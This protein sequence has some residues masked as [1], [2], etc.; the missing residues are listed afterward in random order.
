[1]FTGNMLW[2]Q[3]WRKREAPTSTA[4]LSCMLRGGRGGGGLQ[5]LLTLFELTTMD[6]WQDVMRQGMDSAG[7][8]NQPVTD[9]SASY[10][11]FFVTFICVS[12]FFLSRA[13][14]GVFIKQVSSLFPR[15]QVSIPSMNKSNLSEQLAFVPVSCSNLRLQS[16]VEQLCH[17]MKY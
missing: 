10:A 6:N 4:A 8:N 7:V 13:F 16:W 3:Y 14:V 12:G 17:Y 9:K 5:S 1:M 11:L 15:P 2:S